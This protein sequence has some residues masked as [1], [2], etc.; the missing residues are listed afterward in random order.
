MK[1]IFRNLVQ[2]LYL[3]DIQQLHPEE[4]S[5]WRPNIVLVEFNSWDATDET[6]RNN[7]LQVYLSH[8]TRLQY[9]NQSI[10]KHPNNK[11]KTVLDNFRLIPINQQTIA[12]LYSQLL[13]WDNSENKSEPNNIIAQV[14]TALNKIIC[15]YHPNGTHTLEECRNPR[16]SKKTKMN[17]NKNNNKNANNNTS[18]TKHCSNCELKHPNVS[19]THNTN[20]CRRPGGQKFNPKSSNASKAKAS[21]ENKKSFLTEDISK[22]ITTNVNNAIIANNDFIKKIIHDAASGKFE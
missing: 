11:Y 16:P 20:E 8:A 18:A 6:I 5:L 13:L 2:I 19:N 3:T 22:A 12:N 1:V 21:K 7:G 15:K 10:Q 17:D 9:I 14:N 4:P